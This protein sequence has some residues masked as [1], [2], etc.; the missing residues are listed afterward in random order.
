MDGMIS[1]FFMA[2]SIVNGGGCREMEISFANDGQFAT[3]YGCAIGGMMRLA[4]WK[5][6]HPNHTVGRYKC[7]RTGK[8]ARL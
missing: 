6:E 7:E 8:Y 4:E 1:I 5:N 2:C 3:P